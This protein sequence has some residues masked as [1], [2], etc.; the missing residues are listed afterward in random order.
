MQDE[1]ENQGSPSVV[2]I[3]E[4]RDPAA[5]LPDGGAPAGA[6]VAEPDSAMTNG[7]DAAWDDSPT[8]AAEEAEMSE[9]VESPG[10]DPPD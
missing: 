7:H 2:A 10:D 8:N 6:N 5:G 4:Q 3:D 1:L 9:D